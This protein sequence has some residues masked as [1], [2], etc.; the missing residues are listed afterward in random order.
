MRLGKGSLYEQ[1]H[2][3]FEKT[4]KLLDIWTFCTIINFLKRLTQ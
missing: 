4:K 3:P 2:I 1:S